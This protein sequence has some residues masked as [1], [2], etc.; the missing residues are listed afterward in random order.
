[1]AS[2]DE[3]PTD[4]ECYRQRASS[5]DGENSIPANIETLIRERL[6]KGLARGEME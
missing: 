5:R 2:V 4:A 1:M 6:N 3:S